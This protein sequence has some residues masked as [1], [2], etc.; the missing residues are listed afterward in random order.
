MRA[1]PVEETTMQARRSSIA[2][3]IVRATFSPTTE[4]MLPPMKKKF[5]TATLAGIPPTVATP[6]MAASFSPVSF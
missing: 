6:Q 4:P 3:S 5:M 1:P 2:V